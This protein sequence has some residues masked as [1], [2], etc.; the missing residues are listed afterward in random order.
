MKHLQYG[1]QLPIQSQSTL[2]TEP[3]EAAATPPTSSASPGPPTAPASP[4]S[5][6]ATTSPSPAGSPPR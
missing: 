1:I 6:P 3:W 5:P 2:Y 4:T